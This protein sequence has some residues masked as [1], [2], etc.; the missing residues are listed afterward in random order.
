[1]SDH[2]EFRGGEFKGQ[3]IGKAEFKQQAPAP[4][5][6][7]A[8]PPRAA[9]FTGRDEE[10]GRLRTAL[11][12]A[13]PGTERAVLVTAVSGLGGIGKTALAVQAAYAAREA[14]WFP[15]GVLFVDLHGYDDAPVTADQAL[16]SLLR[17]LGVEPNHIPVTADER[18]ALYR[19]V[20]AER[21][22]VLIVADNASS[23]EQVRPLLP[24]GGLHRVLVTSRDRLAQLGARLVPLDLL[25]PR[26]AYDLLDCALRIADPAD[27]RVVAEPEAVAQLAGLCGHLPLALQ[28]AAALLAEDPGRS[29][30]ELADELATSYDRLDALD[31]GER[32]VRAAFDLSYR[33]LPADEARLLRLLA[34]APGPDVSEEVAAVLAGADAPPL[35]QLKALARAHLLQRVRG[36]W[37]LHDLVRAFCAGVT[38]RTA[39]L[40]E[41]GDAA[42][43]RVL[44]CYC[45]WAYAADDRLRW[46]P[47][48]AQP[49]GFGDHA[50]ALAWLNTERASL[51]EAV[52]WGREE[53]YAAR[54]VILAQCLAIYLEWGRHFDD[55][56]IVSRTAQEAARRIGNR[57][58]EGLAWTSLGCALR[59]MGRLHEAVD[60]HLHARDI[61]QAVGDRE[62]EC[63]LL[64][65]LGLALRDVGRVEE[66]VE[67]HKR[68]RDLCR[69]DGDQHG[70]AIAWTSLGRA[71][72]AA[73]RSAEA[74]DA[75]MRA[76]E[77]F[78]TLGDRRSEAVTWF[79]LADTLRETARAPEAI[80]AFRK[81]LSLYRESKD[82]YW[83][84]RTHAR[85]ADMYVEAGQLSSAGSHCLRAADA[86]TR[87]NAPQEATEARV[88][89]AALTPLEKPTDIPAQAFR[90]A[91]TTDSAQPSPHPPDAP[92]TAVR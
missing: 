90:P 84:A 7:D 54:A 12:P 18:A 66:A 34:L 86:Y 29:V 83:A 43:E 85:L 20:L 31:D 75:L 1:M 88:A 27:S 14:G 3:V 44:A 24:G 58:G 55:W 30:A 4:T 59:Y 13:G 48:Q 25:T 56:F 79:N 41:E 70:E 46:L 65:N 9:G 19:S 28:I 92:G 71:L 35:R 87:A 82:W 91:R 77:L 8:L 63:A 89:A 23:P 2:V 49:E 42:R 60:A 21:E 32:S 36:R 72:E 6:L 76:R 16:Q 39:E 57:L 64:N 45:R 50:Q 78:R 37:R 10:L 69:A 74:I 62:H 53:R 52:L 61:F 11:D 5:A 47:G 22:A 40:C 15:G 81:A 17:A 73:G 67:A 80:E 26:A 68:D 51:V 38:A 33:R